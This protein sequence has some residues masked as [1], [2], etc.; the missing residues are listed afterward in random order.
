MASYD[1]ASASYVMDAGDY[2]IRVGDSSRTTHVAAKIR[3]A[4]TLTTEQVAHEMNQRGAG[5]RTDQQPGEL[6]HLP[7]RNGTSCAGRRPSTLNTRGFK[8]QQNAVRLPAERPGRQLLAVLRDRRQRRSPPPPPTSTRRQTNW[9]G[10]GAPYQA[11]TGETVKAVHTDPNATLYDVAKGKRVDPAVRRRTERRRSW[12]TSSRA[13]APVGRF[14]QAVGAAGY[15]TR[16]YESLGIPGDDAVRRPGRT[17]AHPADARPRRRPT[18]TRP[19]G[20]S[21]R[22]SPRPGTGLW[23]SRSARPSARRCASSAPR[24]GWRPGMNIHRDPLNGRNFEYYSEDPLVA[25]L[26]A[27]ATTKGVQSNPGV[28]VTIKHFVANNQEANR[29]AVERDDRRAGAAG[30]LPAR[31]PD[32]GRD[33]HS[34]WRS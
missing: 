33:R 29:N 18:S 20:R 13:P 5:Q 28:G 34:R 25:G 15:T 6:L 11:K 10:T 3:L 9:E 17:A 7:Q 32:R 22:C 24:C 2:V 1:D 26:T 21:A 31:L 8:T 19:P 23:S 27:A 30:D 14:P 4:K 12:R 16:K